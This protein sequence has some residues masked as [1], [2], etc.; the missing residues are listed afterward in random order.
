VNNMN[1]GRAVFLTKH[2]SEHIKVFTD[3]A[4][5]QLECI[6]TVERILDENEW[7]EEVQGA[8]LMAL[9][10]P[11]QPQLVGGGAAPAFWNRYDPL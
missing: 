1:E 3:K 9:L 5:T 8:I 10:Q 11:G 6:D 7:D 2:A 4:C